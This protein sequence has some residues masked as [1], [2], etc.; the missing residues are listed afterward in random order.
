M[1]YLEISCWSY[2]CSRQRGFLKNNQ[3]MWNIFMKKGPWDIKHKPP[4]VSHQHSRAQ[5]TESTNNHSKLCAAKLCPQDIMSPIQSVS[6]LMW[7]QLRCTI[8]TALE[9]QQIRTQQRKIWNWFHF[10]WG[11]ILIQERCHIWQG[12]LGHKSID[13]TKPDNSKKNMH[14]ISRE[15]TY[16]QRNLYL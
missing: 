5:I 4:R 11:D 10:I 15:V 9:L 13:D 16:A 1:K 6:H 3:N 12:Y 14:V 8:C 2:L 7:R